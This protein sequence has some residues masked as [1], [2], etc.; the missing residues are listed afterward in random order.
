M[1]ITSALS[2][3]F[4]VF[5][6]NFGQQQF[7]LAHLEAHLRPTL[8]IGPFCLR[9]MVMSPS[10]GLNKQFCKTLM[11]MVQRVPVSDGNSEIPLI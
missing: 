6:I 3:D 5:L 9:L 4:I 11:S 10:A 2:V 7:A 1:L 8:L